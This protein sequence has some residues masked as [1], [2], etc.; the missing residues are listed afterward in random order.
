MSR[1][2]ES[3]EVTVLELDAYHW[4]VEI[5]YRE[6]LVREASGLLGDGQRDALRLIATAHTNLVKM[7]D[8]AD[9]VPSPLVPAVADGH[10]GRPHFDIPRSQLEYLVNSRFSVPKIADMLGVSVRTIRRP[11]QE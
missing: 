4:R 1:L 8:S 2:E 6:M 10:V 5:V 3:D 11:M 7:V 9:I